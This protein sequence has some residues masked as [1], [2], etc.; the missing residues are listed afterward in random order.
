M[1][2]LTFKNIFYILSFFG[3]FFGLL[4]GLAFDVLLIIAQPT[5]PNTWKTLVT[6]FAKIIANSQGEI[7]A[8][9]KEFKTGNIT[10]EYANYLVAR[11]VGASLIT[12]AMIYLIYKGM[13][14]FVE[15]PS[16][17]TKMILIIASF[18]IV[19]IL[20]IVAGAI[21]GRINWIPFSGFIDLIKERGVIIDFIIKNYQQKI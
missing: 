18:I 1:V 21:V 9:I 14:F 10:K 19:W 8:A 4:S 2:F 6:D 17:S 3:L 16:F 15:A 12:L 5:N 20:G 7:S 11:I 13:R